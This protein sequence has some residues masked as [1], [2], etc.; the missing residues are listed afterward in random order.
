MMKR[1]EIVSLSKTYPRQNG[2]PVKAVDGLSLSVPAGQVLG[3]T[4]PNGCGKTTVLKMIAG[5]LPPD[6][7]S[8]G[9]NGYDLIQAHD[10]AVQQVQVLVQGVRTLDDRLSTVGNL[11]RQ[12]DLG[13][14]AA[15]LL[16]E[17]GLWERRADPMGALSHGMQHRVAL[18]C[19]LSASHPIILL[20]E[21]TARLDARAAATVE[22]WVRKLAREQG[23]TVVVATGSLRLV[24]ATCDRAAVMADGQLVADTP[25]SQSLSP[26]QQATYRIRVKGNLNADWAAWFDGMSVTATWDETI[27]SGPVT[28]QSALHGLLVKVR[29]LGLPLVSV[30][31][32]L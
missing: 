18:T 21:P 14:A 4:G 24:Q 25:V 19:A 6:A 29:D 32:T 30:E 5:L 28:D 23:Q 26:F 8:V 12:G 17:F 9:L 7:G 11:A 22:T 1:I 15:S 13:P 2:P 31:R 27:I 10:V 3:L 20:D 16:R